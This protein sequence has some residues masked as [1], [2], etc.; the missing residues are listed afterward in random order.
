MPAKFY[1]LR[2]NEFFEDFYWLIHYNEG[3]LIIWELKIRY[4]EG[5]LY[6]GL[7]VYINN[8][9]LIPRLKYRLATTLLS[10][11]QAR[12]VY[13]PVTKAAKRAMDLAS[14]TQ[15]N[16]I[17]HPGIGGFITLMQNQI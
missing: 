6:Q 8:M 1:S 17:A 16:I 12:T 15:T 5:S 9:V 4:I 3:K 11:E 10:E 7:T 2:D 14:T 13:S